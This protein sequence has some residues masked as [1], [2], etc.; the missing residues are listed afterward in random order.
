MA[1]NRRDVPCDV[2]GLE[3]C[4]YWKSHG[5][6]PGAVHLEGIAWR[7]W[8]LYWRI[9]SLGWDMVNAFLTLELT[10]AEAEQVC[11]L[12]AYIKDEESRMA[13][14]YAKRGR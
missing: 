13:R 6:S 14:A 12:V 9:Q 5:L 1:E 11:D 2:G 7:A 8:D 10:A 4:P 3:A